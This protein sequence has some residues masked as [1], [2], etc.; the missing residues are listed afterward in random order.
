MKIA[1]VGA[2][3]SGLSCAE[4][5]AAGD[6]IVK[7]FDK[8]RGPGGRMSTR[9]VTNGQG[10]ASFDHGAQYFTARD[11]NFQTVVA[12]WHRRGIVDR[13]P[14][15]GDDAW[16]GVPAMNAPVKAL[17]AAQDV[18]WSSRIDALVK[19][20]DGWEL[21]GD[22]RS[23]GLLFDA[24]ILAIPAEQAK[25]LVAPWDSD[26]QT[27]AQN[28]ISE[29]CWTVMLAFADPIQTDNIIIRNDSI[30]G[31]ATRNTD[32]P[33]RSGPDS[34]VIQGTPEWS[35]KH[36]EDSPEQIVSAL[37]RHFFDLLGISSANVLVA[38]AHRWRYARSGKSDHGSLYNSELRIGVCGDWMLG[39]R[40]ECAWLSG[41]AL[42]QKIIA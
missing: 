9:R 23:I 6:H 28:A 27:I 31:W 3:L 42:A 36:L 16:V 34:W 4:K 24:V 29:P 19:R 17:A 22:S 38:S 8:G 33:G 26:F 7:L 21:Q 18:Q 25:S 40:V 13:W 41:S 32:K 30:I 39:P 12:D 20:E 1:I 35:A 11:P 14:A 5:L 15:A 2:G 10:E 37:S